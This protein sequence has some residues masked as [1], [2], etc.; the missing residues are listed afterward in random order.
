MQKY[1]DEITRYT[2]YR[3]DSVSNEV[4]NFQD[5]FQ[6]FG[7]IALLQE[8]PAFILLFRLSTVP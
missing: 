1:L 2:S 8:K 7:N 5:K 6:I 4:E 3:I